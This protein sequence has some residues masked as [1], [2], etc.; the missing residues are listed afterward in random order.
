MSALV[1]RCA[2][3]EV[4]KLLSL[5]SSCTYLKSAPVLPSA[6]RGPVLLSAF[7]QFASICSVDAI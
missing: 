6:V 4:E 5:G 3:N 7:R 2:T 1:I